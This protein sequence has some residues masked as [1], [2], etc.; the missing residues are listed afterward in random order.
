MSFSSFLF[1]PASSCSCSSGGRCLVKRN[2]GSLDK[3]VH[4]IL[5]LKLDCCQ[6]LPAWSLYNCL[7]CQSLIFSRRSKVCCCC[8]C[9]SS[10]HA[11]SSL[12]QT[13][14]FLDDSFTF[15]L[16]EEASSKSCKS[17][18]CWQ[19][20]CELFCKSLVLMAVWT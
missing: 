18:C 4:S 9:C 8:C 14:Y 19:D 10:S 2:L 17:C 7:L 5:Q 11:T 12:N 6:D 3:N 15:L 1:S 13:Q 16:V 20:A